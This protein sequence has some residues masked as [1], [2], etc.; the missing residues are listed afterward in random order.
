[1]SAKII[2]ER[3][4]TVP[5][6]E[7][8][9][10]IE[11]VLTEL[12]AKHVLPAFKAEEL[13][14]EHLE[15]ARDVLLIASILKPPIIPLLGQ[16]G[17]ELKGKIQSDLDQ[18]MI[19]SH[20]AGMALDIFVP[21]EDPLVASAILYELLLD[22]QF[23]AIKS[24]VVSFG[25]YHLDTRSERTISLVCSSTCFE[26]GGGLYANNPDGFHAIGFALAPR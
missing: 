10:E 25:V 14:P 8:Q 11:Q 24:I 1:M 13:K 3:L 20:N 15:L 16:P 2:L 21:N 5:F 9:R 7:V 22:K 26:H 19:Q 17:V 23:S 12:A 6:R 18:S 4:M